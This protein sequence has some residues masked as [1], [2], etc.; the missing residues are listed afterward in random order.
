MISIPNPP[1]RKL[2]E[3]DRDSCAKQE[4]I[5]EA[6]RTLLRSVQ[7]SKIE[8]CLQCGSSRDLRKATVFL[9]GTDET[10]EISLPLCDRCA[11]LEESGSA[12]RSDY[13]S[14]EI[15]DCVRSEVRVQ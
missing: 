13:E 2:L 5:R 7:A 12:A 9:W 14:S 8:T 1:E 15:A 4:S 10:W 6:L 3:L 11:L